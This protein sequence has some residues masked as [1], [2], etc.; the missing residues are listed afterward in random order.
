MLTLG[1]YSIGTGDLFG[2]QA[3]TQLESVRKAGN[4]IT[5]IW[6]KSYREHAIILTDPASALR[7]DQKNPAY[8]MHLRQLLHLVIRLL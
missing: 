6:N 7:H 8:N 5:I 4:D 2:K 1:K 3:G